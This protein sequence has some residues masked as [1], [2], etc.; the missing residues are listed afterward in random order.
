MLLNYLLKISVVLSIIY[1]WGVYWPSVNMGRITAQC[2]INGSFDLQ[3][4]L[5]PECI[6]KI[7]III[8]GC[9][10]P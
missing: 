2:K 7:Q 10:Y 1:S 3:K 9:D 5:F 8:V 4:F 6:R